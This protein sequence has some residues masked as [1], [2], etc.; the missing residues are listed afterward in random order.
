MKKLSA[1]LN[2]RTAITAISQVSNLV[3]F[4]E[5]AHN[6]LAANAMYDREVVEQLLESLLID[7]GNCLETVIS[8]FKEFQNEV[9]PIN[10][11]RRDDAL[12][13]LT[14]RAFFKAFDHLSVFD[15]LYD[16]WLEYNVETWYS[17]HIGMVL[18]KV[19]DFTNQYASSVSAYHKQ[20]ENSK[21]QLPK[22]EEILRGKQFAS[23]IKRTQ[24]WKELRDFMK[25]FNVDEAVKSESTSSA[26]IVKSIFVEID[27]FITIVSSK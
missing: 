21:L 26:A 18:D 10:E 14:P 9:E 5:Y 13:N 23:T 6:T 27:K 2:K 19:K 22:A 1:Q 4:K 15:A 8:E 17:K 16:V 7:S 12:I 3:E 11:G 24:E 20:Y 25:D